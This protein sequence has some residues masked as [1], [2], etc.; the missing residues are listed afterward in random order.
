M[1][2]IYNAFYFENKSVKSPN[3]RHSKNI[4]TY[5]QQSYVSLKS[6]KLSNPD[7]E[8]AIVSNKAIPEKYRD[9]FQKEGINN[10]IV[11][12]TNYKMPKS[13]PWEFAFYKLEVLSYMADSDHEYIL[14]VDMDTY[15]SDDLEAL[16]KECSYH[17][18]I[19]YILPVSST[20][21]TRRNMIK[22]Y[23][24]MSGECIPILHLG[25]EFIAGSKQALAL[26]S[27]DLKEMYKKISIGGFRI[28][29]DS[30][31]EAI[32]SMA[33]SKRPFNCGNAFV[34]RYWSRRA[35]YNVDSA[36]KWT[37][38]WHLPAEKNYGLIIMYKYLIKHDKLMEKRKAARLFN[39]P[40]Q[41]RYNISMIRY[42]LFNLLRFRK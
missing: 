21:E 35:F 42:Y 20:T 18:P 38:I 17:R 12:F 24:R 26:L 34:H 3:M 1:N 14:G 28:S 36:W 33:A 32:L 25:G 6:A 10:I 23:Q 30:G 8:V 40:I 37:P 2:L 5:L 11:P 29:V 27:I 22:D 15:F 7:C 31:D 13:F 39:L 19:F 16:W 41:H 9:R 4:D